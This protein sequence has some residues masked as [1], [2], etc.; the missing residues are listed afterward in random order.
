[1]PELTIGSATTRPGEIVTGW[2]DAVT[3]PTGG[4][5]RFPVIIAQ[6][7]EADGPVLWVTASIHGGEHTGLITVQRLITPE[8]VA[9]LHGTLIAIPTLN[10]AGLRVKERRPYYLDGDPNR[11]FPEPARSAQESA[12][13][14]E[15]PPSGLQL[16][17][18]RL[19]EA[20]VASG[21]SALIDLHNAWIGS[22]PFVFRDPIFFQRGRAGGRKGLPTRAQAQTLMERVNA[23]LDAFGF[24]IV[25]EFVA[26]SYVRKNLHRSVS[27]SVL[28]GAG[29]PAF[30]VELGSWL[31]VEP[32]IVE[33]CLVGLRNVM[34]RL[35]MLKS[36]PE[37]IEGIPVL[38][39]DY[40]VR[41]CMHPYAPEAGIVHM[42]VQ[43]GEPVSKGQ[44]LARL[45]DIFGQPVGEDGGTLRS[46]H[47][48]FVL[49]W[50]HGVVRYRG[51][52]IM[53]LA[54]RDEDSLIVPYPA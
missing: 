18:Q 10:P 36:A 35:G 6:G 27:G 9:G 49:G 17:Y 41:R 28:N 26:D 20:I 11:L 32:R 43:P 21:A 53:V 22:V 31:Y 14:D 42:L 47:D 7:K 1:M 34:R 24:T 8:L 4:A 37:P 39:P 12:D 45:T 54:I 51:E 44:A 33:A 40:P 50:P 23:L 3:L 52:P 46:A 29:I 19:Y 30:T 5:D 2:F 25:N 38:R 15:K 48:G 16:A 13:P